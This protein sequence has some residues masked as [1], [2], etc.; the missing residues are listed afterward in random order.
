MAKP[1]ANPPRTMIPPAIAIAAATRPRRRSSSRGGRAWRSYPRSKSVLAA[2]TV[3]RAPARPRR[4]HH[5]AEG[6]GLL[7]ADHAREAAIGVAAA[8]A[9]PDEQERRDHLEHPRA[10]LAHLGEPA[11]PEALEDARRLARRE[12]RVVRADRDPEAVA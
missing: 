4:G 3:P 5:P 8:E 11:R 2:V 1:T 10:A 12:A 7:L 6:H 9:R